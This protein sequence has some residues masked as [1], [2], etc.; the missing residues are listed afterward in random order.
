MAGHAL[1]CRDRRQA[2]VQRSRVGFVAEESK[3]F[4]DSRQAQMIVISGT[5]P[6]PVRIK[7]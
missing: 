7:I 2:R 3:G 6:V 5:E 1:A 4:E